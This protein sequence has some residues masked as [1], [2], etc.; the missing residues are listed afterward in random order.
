MKILSIEQQMT[1]RFMENPAVA[2][3]TGFETPR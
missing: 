3:R 1:R 2:L